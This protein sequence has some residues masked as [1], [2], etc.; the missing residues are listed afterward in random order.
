MAGATAKK[1]MNIQFATHC[2]IAK[3]NQT[4]QTKAPRAFGSALE[5]PFIDT[6]TMR[7]RVVPC[8][9]GL[10]KRLNIREMTRFLKVAKTTIIITL[11]GIVAHF[12]G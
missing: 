11:S 2:G 9:R 4:S 1:I 6:K 5:G 7:V 12:A 8:K 3:T 10:E